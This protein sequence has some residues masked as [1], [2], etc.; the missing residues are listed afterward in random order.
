MADVSD[1]HGAAVTLHLV[2]VTKVSEQR[3]A[4]E[5]ESCVAT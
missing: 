4:W 5:E 2:S 3:P 1:E